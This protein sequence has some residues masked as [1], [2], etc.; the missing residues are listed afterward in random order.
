[1]RV[2]PEKLPQDIR[3]QLRAVYLISGEETLLVQ[4]CCAQVRAAARRGGWPRRRLP[5]RCRFHR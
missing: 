4:E 1:M 5:C 3:R 2:Y